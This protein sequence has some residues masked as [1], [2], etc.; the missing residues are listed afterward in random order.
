MSGSYSVAMVC[1]NGHAVNTHADSR[2]DRNEKY[3]SDC[4]AETIT[5][6]VNCNAPIRGRYM[7]PGVILAGVYTAPS[8]CY[9]CGNAYPW[10]E[11]KIQAAEELADEMDKLTPEEREQ[12]KR[13]IHDIIRDT[14]QTPVAATRFKRLV[15]KAG[16]KMGEALWGIVVDIASETAKKMIIP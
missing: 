6:C 1:L 16:Q 8:F 11:A 4:G 10:T 9:G 2:P 7:T 15:G 12:L 13:S 14:P 3:C 5:Q